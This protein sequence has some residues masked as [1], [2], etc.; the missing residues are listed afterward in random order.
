MEIIDLLARFRAERPTPDGASPAELFL[1]RR[2][3]PTTT[4][5]L[6]NQLLDKQT[7]LRGASGAAA[8]S[9]NSVA[10]AS[11]STKATLDAF[12]VLPVAHARD[13]RCHRSLHLQAVR[14]PGLECGQH[15]KVRRRA[16]ELRHQADA[17]WSS[18]RTQTTQTTDG[19]PT[20]SSI[21]PRLIYREGL[22]MCLN[23][24]DQEVAETRHA[25]FVFYIMSAFF[26]FCQ[27]G[28][29]RYYYYCLLSPVTS[30]FKKS[31]V[32]WSSWL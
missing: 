21:L 3:V 31:I 11:S 17:C 19:R 10:E 4:H 6:S 28:W 14:R 8:P 15:T 26:V 13:S 24:I 22:M 18:C 30:L 5:K 20:S 25:K 9:T 16:I 23:D 32:L 12:Y 29:W 7:R 27:S 2:A 1:G